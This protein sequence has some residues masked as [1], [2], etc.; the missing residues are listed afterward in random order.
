MQKPIRCE[1]WGIEYKV[2]FDSWIPRLFKKDAWTFAKMIHVAD[3]KKFPHG[4]HAHEWKHLQQQAE[5]GLWKFTFKYLIQAL[6]DG[7]E[8]IDYEIEA[9]KF[10][11][12][13]VE[14]WNSFSDLSI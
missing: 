9:R 6:L 14:I 4:L 2:Y 8:Y 3:A 12:E 13:E 1:K 10:Q 5:D 7:Y 11:K